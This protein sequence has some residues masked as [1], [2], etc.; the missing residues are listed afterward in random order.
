MLAYTVRRILIL[1][2]VLLLVSVLVFLMLHLI[3]GSPE[4]ALLGLTATQEQIEATRARLGLDKPL[5]VQYGIFLINAV[6]GDFGRSILSRKPV[7]HEI[8]TRMWPTFQLGLAAA[9]IATVL[10]ISTGTISAL[11]RGTI[12]DLAST[13]VA[14]LGISVPVYWLGLMLMLVFAV[15]LEWLPSAGRDGLAHLIIP[16]FTLGTYSTSV[17]SRMTRTCVLRVLAADHVRT[18]HA[19]GLSRKAVLARHVLRNALVPIVTIVGLQLGSLLS[20]AVIT[21]TVFAWPG[22]G[23]LLVDSVRARD[24]PVV[25]ALILFFAV[26]FSVLNLVTDILYTYLDPRMRCN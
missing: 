13:G 14:T 25:Q 2:P 10:G 18:A 8:G 15:R 4:R 6:Q 19:K 26:L 24:Y 9:A 11:S 20:G 16:A 22:I 1:I 3:P 7:T 23:K 17:I 5:P 21:E 12:I